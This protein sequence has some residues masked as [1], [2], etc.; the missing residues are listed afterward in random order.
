MVSSEE[1][2]RDMSPPDDWLGAQAAFQRHRE[3]DRLGR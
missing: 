2:F 1:L 3:A